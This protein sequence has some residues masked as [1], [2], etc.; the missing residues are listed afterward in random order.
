MECLSRRFAARMKDVLD[1]E[2]PVI[3]TVALKGGGF[4][5]EVKARGDTQLFELTLKNRD[6]L[7]EVIEE[8]VETLTKRSR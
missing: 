1:S 7:E 5:A 2:T 6:S 3:A 8:Y 4:I